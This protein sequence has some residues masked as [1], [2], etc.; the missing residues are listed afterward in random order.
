MVTKPVPRL[1]TRRR[2]IPKRIAPLPPMKSVSAVGLFGKYSFE[3]FDVY[4]RDQD[5]PNVTLLYGENGVG[6][7]TLLKLIYATLADEYNR[8]LKGSIA[9]T[10]FLRFEIKFADGQA[11][12]LSRDEPTDGDYTFSLKGPRQNSS[13]MFKMNAAKRVAISD[14]GGMDEFLAKVSQ[15]TPNIVFINDVR[16]IRSSKPSWN[17][18]DILENQTSTTQGTRAYTDPLGRPLTFDAEMLASAGLERLLEQAH[19]YVR[20]RAIRT[21]AVANAGTGQI[22]TS[23]AKTLFQS[24]T[25]SENIDQDRI[26]DLLLRIEKSQEYIDQFGEYTLLQGEHLGDLLKYLRDGRGNAQHQIYE[27]IEPYVISIEKRI[28]ESKPVADQIYQFETTINDFLKRKKMSFRVSSPASFTDEGGSELRVE[29]LSSGER[30]L[31]YMLCIS[32]LSRDDQAIVLVDEPELSLNY[33]WQRRLVSSMLDV[34]SIRSQFIM[35]T[36]SFEVISSFRDSTVE[37]EPK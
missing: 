4:G 26:T 9:N 29:N 33:K 21:N 19:S 32:M 37:L 22:Y 27:L 2:F 31:L 13:L 17:I 18:R 36:H 3:E 5:N 14:N 6:K 1:A 24:N 25:K 28:K 35:A 34:S 23:I 12:I 15:I 8:G 20:D 11:I 10:I 30:H 16:S 7:T